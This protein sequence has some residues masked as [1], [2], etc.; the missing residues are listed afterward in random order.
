[1]PPILCMLTPL[2]SYFVTPRD[3]KVHGITEIFRIL[4]AVGH[5]AEPA[6]RDTDRRQHPA[7]AQ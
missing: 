3:R 1:M 7:Y 4:G 5:T 6:V 2:N